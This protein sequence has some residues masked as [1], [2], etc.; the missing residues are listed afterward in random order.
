MTTA[1]GAAFTWR[2][3]MDVEQRFDLW[4]SRSR[5]QMAQVQRVDAHRAG[6]FGDDDRLQRALLNAVLGERT[7]LRQQ[8]VARRHDRQSRQNHRAELAAAIDEPA[9]RVAI[10]RVHVEIGTVD[11]VMFGK[12]RT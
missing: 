11:P 5:V 3:R 7:V 2:A 12:L 4:Q 1:P 6:T 8:V 9:F 10:A